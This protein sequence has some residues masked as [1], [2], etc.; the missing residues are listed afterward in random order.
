MQLTRSF[1]ALH[2][3]Y[4][5]GW[6]QRKCSRI[7]GKSEIAR[8]TDSVAVVSGDRHRVGRA[9]RVSRLTEHPRRTDSKW[10]SRSPRTRTLHPGLPA[11]PRSYA[12]MRSITKI[13]VLPDSR[14]PPVSPY[15]R[16]GGITSWRRPP[17]FIP[18]IPSCH[19]AIRPLS[20][21]EIDS[22]R[23]QEASN[24]SPLSNS[25]PR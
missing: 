16:R 9:P 18:G 12:S 22:P 14:C 25:T 4:S 2:D 15:A 7:R 17:T 11:Y 1:R 20:G 6:A 21:N 8:T 5:A 13:S 10:V 24:C 19:P 3:I 23:S